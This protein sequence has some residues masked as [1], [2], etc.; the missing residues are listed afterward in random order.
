MRTPCQSSNLVPVAA[1]QRFLLGATPS[2]ELSFK[3]ECFVSRA[4]FLREDE[5]DRPA[6]PRV[7]RTAD[8][9]CGYAPW[10]DLAERAQVV[11]R[12][13]STAGDHRQS[14][15]FGQGR[16]RFDVHAALGS[17]ARDVREEESRDAAALAV[18][19]GVGGRNV[20]RLR[21]PTRRHASI[22]RVEGDVY[23]AGELANDRI[24]ELRTLERRRAEYQARRS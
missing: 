20:A 4:Q 1:N 7:E 3:L 5:V 14:H 6:L 22:T 9:Y 18:A 11:G 8:D 23:T 17:V 10:L 16:G 19:G 13:H 12:C 24:D 15:R 2:L 21:P